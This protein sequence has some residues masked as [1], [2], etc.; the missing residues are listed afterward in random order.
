MNTMRRKPKYITTTA[1]V[2][3]GIT[4]LAD[5]VLQ[6]SE[7]KEK[8]ASLTWENFDGMRTLKRSVIGG[9]IGGGLGY[10]L[11]EHRLAVE[12][13]YTFYSN[14][15]L[16]RLLAEENLRSDPALFEKFIFYKS[17]VQDWLHDSYADDLVC[18]PILAGS[19]FKRTAIASNCDLDILLAFKRH[20]FST[21]EL[22]YSD[23]H[24]KITDRYSAKATIIKTSRAIT[25]YFDDNGMP[26]QVDILPGRETGN[27]QKDHQLMFHVNPSWIF[28]DSTWT[29]TNV[30]MQKNITVN[31]PAAR[32]IIKLVKLYRDRNGYYL[33]SVIIEHCVVMALD[34]DNCSYSDTVN[35][36][37]CMRFI[38]KVLQW[39][40]L[41]DIANN[42]RNLL[43]KMSDGDR[44]Y[45]AEQLESDSER[46][47]TN[48]RYLKEIFP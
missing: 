43:D 37:T 44:Y 15:F 23:V 27:F 31:F 14:E 47:E 45:M 28:G 36:L 35:L 4:A 42:N 3:A 11:Y 46:I 41:P 25:L 17:Q 10:L 26:I 5:V 22:M 16:A 21:L 24:K 40:L 9:A 39:S 38:A 8:G 30:R 20:S 2:G 13:Q 1:I 19:F 6:W 34:G 29:K 7:Q 33:P 18:P 32:R 12:S 48:H